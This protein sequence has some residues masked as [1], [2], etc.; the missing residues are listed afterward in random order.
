MNTNDQGYGEP[1][2]HQRPD[3]RQCPHCMGIGTGSIKPDAPAR[4]FIDHGMIHDR[5][6]DRHV[7][8]EDRPDPIGEALELLN[9]LAKELEQTKEALYFLGGFGCDIPLSLLGNMSA[10]DFMKKIGL[11]KGAHDVA[12]MEMKCYGEANSVIAKLHVEHF[13]QLASAQARIAELEIR[14]GDNESFLA[15]DDCYYWTPEA[16]EKHKQ[17][18]TAAKAENIGNLQLIGDLQEE[19]NRLM[20]TPGGK[21]IYGALN[22][23]TRLNAEIERLLDS[24]AKELGQA[25][26]RIKE[27]SEE[28]AKIASDSH[29]VRNSGKRIAELEAELAQTKLT[30]LTCDDINEKN[31]E[32]I[33]ELE[34][35]NLQLLEVAGQEHIDRTMAQ[36]ENRAAG[37][38]EQKLVAS[39]ENK[40]EVMESLNLAYAVRIDELKAEIENLL[41]ALEKISELT[42]WNNQPLEQDFHDAN[43]VALKA[44]KAHR[45]EGGL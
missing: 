5:V 2:E 15:S 8:G 42:I 1:C 44:L 17:E 18:L 23:I 26:A 9:S 33:K 35:E 21:R 20:D 28:I 12:G 11:P 3:Y 14:V 24:R 34:A 10:I 45:G 38:R 30:Q 32:R 40:D 19:I 22:E 43:E 16:A 7:F 13:K 4:F 6:T 25:N 36:A 29:Y 27:L 39:L 37:A 41:R 31:K